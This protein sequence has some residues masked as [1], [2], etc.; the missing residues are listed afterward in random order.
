M[1]SIEIMIKRFKGTIERSSRNG[2]GTED[3]VTKIQCNFALNHNAG[4]VSLI[5]NSNLKPTRKPKNQYVS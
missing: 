5:F 1:R 4:N 3:P 2:P